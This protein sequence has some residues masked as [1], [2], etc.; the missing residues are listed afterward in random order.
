M[1]AFIIYDTNA[2]TSSV[3]E[4]MQKLNYQNFCVTEEG[5]KYNLPNTCLWRENTK[6]ETAI[7][8]LKLVIDQLNEQRDNDERYIVL[9]RCITLPDCPWH[10]VPGMPTK[11]CA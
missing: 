6:L 9:E 11:E 3:K 8:D 2:R 7:E 4:E 1:H 10:A 5:V